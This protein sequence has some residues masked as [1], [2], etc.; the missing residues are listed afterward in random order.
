MKFN[1]QKTKWTSIIE[2]LQIIHP[3]PYYY[4]VAIIVAGMKMQEREMKYVHF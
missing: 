4:I 1:W 2:K 3:P